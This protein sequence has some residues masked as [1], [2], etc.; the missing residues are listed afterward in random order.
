MKIPN[1]PLLPITNSASPTF[2]LIDARAIL[3][4]KTNLDK[5]FD[6][7]LIKKKLVK[8]NRKTNSKSNS[9]SSKFNDKPHPKFNRK[10]RRSYLRA[11]WLRGFEK[12]P[13]RTSK[14]VLDGT[15]PFD[16]PNSLPPGT[17]EF[18]KN[19]FSKPTNSPDS[20]QIDSDFSTLF[21]GLMDPITID[22]LK[23]NFESMR[24]TSPGLDR[25]G[26]ND[27][28]GLIP[29]LCDWFNIFL[30]VRDIPSA[31]KRFYTT[32]I[33]KK[34]SPETPGDFRPI[35]VGSFIRRLFSKILD[36]RIKAVIPFHKAQRGFKHEEGCAIQ[37]HMLR[38]IVN[39]R[40]S[41][42]RPLNYAFLDVKK[43][44]DSIDHSVL[45][46]VF[47]ANRLPLSLSQ[48]LCNV[49]HGNSTQ[50]SGIGL[51]IPIQRGVL[52]GD[53]LSPT[54]FNMV[55]EVVNLNLRTD[56]GVQFGRS[57]INHLLYT[58][59]SVLLAETPQGLQKLTDSFTGLLGEYGLSVNSQ[60]CAS[61]SICV[62][63]K[64][65][66]W[67]VN[68]KPS[69]QINNQFVKPLRISD[70]Y[71]YLGVRLSAA[72]KAVSLARSKFDSMLPRLKSSVL[73]PQQKLHILR[74]VMVPRLSY[75]L[76]QSTTTVNTLYNIDRGIRAFVRST[77]H[78][79]KDTPL[80]AFHAAVRDGGMG[81]PSLRTSIPTLQ[82]LQILRIERIKNDP[83]VAS[84]I[85]SDYWSTLKKRVLHNVRSFFDESDLDKFT[86]FAHRDW[87]RDR[88]YS[89][90]DGGG[91]R[92][93]GS[94]SLRLNSW[95][96]D[97]NRIKS[98]GREYV[99][100]LQ[101]KY[102]TLQTRERQSRGREGITPTSR[103]RMCPSCPDKLGTLAHLLQVCGRTSRLRIARHNEIVEVLNSKL[104]SLGYRT[105]VEPRL[106]HRSSWLQPDLIA[107][108][109][110]SRQLLVID[111]TI[112][113]DAFPLE[114]SYQN[115]IQKY[116]HTSLIPHICA[117]LKVVNDGK[118][119]LLVVPAVLS[120]RGCWDDKSIKALKS[121]GVGAW[122]LELITF[123]VLVSSRAIYTSDRLRTDT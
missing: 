61:V 14:R 25:I 18:W 28:K 11:L 62:N 81:V 47:R 9:H 3:N 37:T 97:A 45:S 118:N 82:L 75:D 92:H 10:A 115:K 119:E 88:L 77:L 50:I 44:F 8:P 2:L 105:Y 110:N 108:K 122:T 78:L 32:L 16:Q 34:P 22:E 109:P 85:G 1:D 33:P 86:R 112:V 6:N 26:L 103:V 117:K 56:I 100:A 114:V 40:V 96:L 79:P 72:G 101:V 43:A 64:H 116:T 98:S 91:L 59:D 46:R 73:K 58:D 111:P 31:L 66:K 68:S 69:L 48:L 36:A 7:W 80:G 54:V 83:P 20:A 99:C 35:S 89:S 60:K 41:N 27:L 17:Q 39:N 90:V 57:Q 42:L 23:I 63:G 104:K 12:H 24:K 95:L 53:P 93:Y 87:W 13:S 106:D 15:G 29:E 94:A 52:Q 49:Y 55:L 84:L 71:N 5:H 38:A 123:R 107:V 121:I 65:K 113:S 21:N 74:S 76:T 19:L 30:T 102:A 4:D 51:P 70:S 120:W 67:Y